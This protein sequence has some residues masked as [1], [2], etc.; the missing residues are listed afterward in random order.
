MQYDV[1]PILKV[2]SIYPL[3]HLDEEDRR[4]VKYSD[5]DTMGKC[6]F[7]IH[8]LKIMDLIL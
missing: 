7:S 8:N 5:Q 2:R 3:L 1:S 4:W 6:R